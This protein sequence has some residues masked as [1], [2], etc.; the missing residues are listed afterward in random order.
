M[1]GVN[2]AARNYERSYIFFNF[3][4]IIGGTGYA[5]SRA[6]AKGLFEGYATSKPGLKA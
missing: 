5:L 3:W 6:L 1:P 4:F 2:I